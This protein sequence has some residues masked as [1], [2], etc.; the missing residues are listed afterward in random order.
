MIALKELF[1]QESIL[2]PEMKAIMLLNFTLQVLV[3]KYTQKRIFLVE[4]FNYKNTSD[5]KHI[6][7]SHRF[8]QKQCTDGVLY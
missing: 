7:S 5:F 3:P 2:S 6:V 1:L 4:I 8:L